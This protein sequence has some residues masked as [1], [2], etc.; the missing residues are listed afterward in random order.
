MALHWWT[1]SPEEWTAIRLS[2]WVS[3]IAMFA[4][5]PFGIAVAVALARGRFWG[6][7]L[8]NGIVHLPLILPPVVTG[9]LLLVLFGR[10]GAIGQFLD[11]WFGIVFSFR[12]TGAAL[13]CA[14]M[15]FPLMVRSIRLSIE[16]VDSK[17][18]EAAGTL[19][20]SPL[21]VF[22]TV[23]LPLI[24]PGIIAGMILA[25]AKAMGEFGATI[26]FV[27]NIPGETQTLSAAIYTFTQVPGGDAGALRLTIVSVVISMLALLV[28][29]FL[30]RIIGK[31]VSME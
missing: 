20:A 29:E 21:W 27:S 31:R 1:L 26:T 6:K 11:S 24:L 5:L 13:A 16:A 30:A 12:W 2:L 9:F 18:E 15:A 23:T 14:V 10:R 7:S 17:L 19:G 3:S 28:S 22:L 4:S 8:L 25:F